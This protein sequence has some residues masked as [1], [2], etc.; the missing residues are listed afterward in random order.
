MSDD[1]P[2]NETDETTEEMVAPDGDSNVMTRDWPAPKPDGP[3]IMNPLG[4]ADYTEVF[5]TSVHQPFPTE[6]DLSP[7]SEAGPEDTA[8]DPIP[9]G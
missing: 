8:E 9:V 7:K 1:S 4:E 6:K 3:S 5:T 2:A